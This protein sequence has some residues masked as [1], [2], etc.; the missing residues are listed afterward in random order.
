[1]N[2]NYVNNSSITSTIPTGHY[3]LVHHR[4]QSIIYTNPAIDTKF[5]WLTYC[6][7]ITVVK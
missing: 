6:Y 4:F 5:H 2:V 1:M 3:R 7:C